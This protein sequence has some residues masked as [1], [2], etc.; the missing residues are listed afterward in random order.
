MILGKENCTRDSHLLF[1]RVGKD[2][3]KIKVKLAVK[4]NHVRK[5]KVE[6]GNGYENH[7]PYNLWF[8]HPFNLRLLRK[9][10]TIGNIEDEESILTS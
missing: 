9:Q 10:Q 6:L 8:N 5:E 4:H 2:F 3:P 1:Q 7:V